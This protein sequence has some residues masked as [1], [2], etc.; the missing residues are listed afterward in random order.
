MR[1]GVAAIVLG[2]LALVV[3]ACGGNVVVDGTT[4]TTTN[5]SSSSSSGTGA[6]PV[7]SNLSTEQ[8]P[9]GGCQTK[10]TCNG[11][12]AFVLCGVGTGS[13]DGCYCESYGSPMGTCQGQASSPNWCSPTNG[14]CA[15]YFGTSGG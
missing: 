1:K 4:T 11:T 10:G 6:A 15:S 12:I 13:P 14:C 9:N 2:C 3:V 8:R 5:G 7:C